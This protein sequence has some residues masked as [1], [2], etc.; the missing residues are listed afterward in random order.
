MYLT[1]HKSS[2]VISFMISRTSHYSLVSRLKLLFRTAVYML[3]T[4]FQECGFN[5]TLQLA[6]HSF[7][8]RDY[9]LNSWQDTSESTHAR[10]IEA[11]LYSHTCMLCL[12]IMVIGRE[13]C[14]FLPFHY[15]MVH[16]TGCGWKGQPPY[17]EGTANI[18]N[19]QEQQVHKWWSYRL[20]AVWGV[21][22]SSR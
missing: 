21:N 17:M 18:M 7:M 2:L 8:G 20:G 13:Q 4:H 6:F 14:L 15:G 3:I 16:P 9:N 19:R 22:V 12:V 11:W 10:S 1:E 5:I